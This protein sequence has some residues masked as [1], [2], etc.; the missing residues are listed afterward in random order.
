MGQLISQH[1]H[2]GTH[3]THFFLESPL[4]KLLKIGTFFFSFQQIPFE[5]TASFRR[6]ITCKKLYIFTKANCPLDWKKNNNKKKKKKKKKQPRHPPQKYSS[7]LPS[8]PRPPPRF[9][10]EQLSAVVFWCARMC[11]YVCF[12]ISSLKLLGQLKPNFMWNL[13]GIGEA[14]LF[15]WSR[16]FVVLHYCQPPGGGGWGRAFSRDFTIN[17]SPQCRA[18]SRALKTEKLKAPLFP[19]PVG[20]GTTNDWCI[21]LTA[22][23]LGTREIC[24]IRKLNLVKIHCSL[25]VSSWVPSPDFLSVSFPSLVLMLSYL[26][27]KENMNTVINKLILVKHSITVFSFRNR[28]NRKYLNQ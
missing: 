9:H 19:G 1:H 16:S 28:L 27:I 25:S 11:V 26:V 6:T 7:A 15:K 22:C 21:T 13:H 2:Y 8:K 12:P 23:L 24:M 3:I 5:L 17:L 4:L 20:T 10:L 18:F 14:S